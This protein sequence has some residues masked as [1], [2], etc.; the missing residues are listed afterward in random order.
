MRS[1]RA[2]LIRDQFLV[3]TV[4][5]LVCSIAFIQHNISV[6]RH[7]LENSVQSAAKVIGSSLVAPLSFLDEKEAEKVLRSLTAE[8]H[9]LQA[10]VFDFT[11]RHFAG[12]GTA[13]PF[14]EL[15]SNT[16]GFSKFT[17]NK[18][19]YLFPL[20]NDKDGIGFLYIEASLDSLQQSYR[21]YA[22]IVLSVLFGGL[23]LC[24]VLTS[25]A[26]RLV[27]AP[28][29]SLLSAMQAVSFSGNYSTVTH[30]H[31]E[32]SSIQE[33]RG[34]STEFEKMLAQIKARDSSLRDSNE[35]LEKKVDERTKQLKEAEAMAMQKTKMT[36]LGEMASGV[37]HEINNPLAII[38]GKASL[39]RESISEGNV[40]PAEIIKTIQKIESTA[41][42]ISKIVKNLRVFSRDVSE[43]PFQTISVKTLLHDTLELCES[44]FQSHGIRLSQS[45]CDPSLTIECRA[46]QISQVLL[47]LLNNAHDA[48][49]NLEDKWINIEVVD[50]N[51]SVSFF[52]TDSGAGIP[53]EIQEKIMQPFFTTKDPDK[54]TGLG[55][56]ISKGITDAHHG[57]LELNTRSA[58]TCFVLTLPKVQ[59]PVTASKAEQWGLA[60]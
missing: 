24:L 40:E 41:E 47:N 29:H 27:S 46:P 54:G 31:G 5:L 38:F 44:K 48:I 30:K 20:L 35:L 6:Y 39:L 14:S 58:H 9:I 32:N 55:L 3:T 16:E 28:I 17:G 4:V 11:G 56:S 18:Y 7:S 57:K 43:D 13:P 23:V 34:L 42:R 59:P 25:Q 36:S 60:G 15:S 12:Y 22:G 50:L 52:I 53:V 45:D 19:T 51:E 33:I 8:Q 37:A 1:L 26:Q 2:Q 21:Q 10:H 49:L